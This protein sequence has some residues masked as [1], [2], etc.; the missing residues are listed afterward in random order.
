MRRRRARSR[1]R[2]RCL[3]PRIR[4]GG[5]WSPSRGSVACCA[6]LLLGALIALPLLAGGWLWLRQSLVRVRAARADRGRARSRGAGCGRGADAGG[7]SHE[8]A[9][10]E[11]RRAL[12]AAVAPLLVVRAVR[13]IP[14]LP[15]RP[16]HRG[17]RAAAR[18]EPHG[19][20]RAHSGGRRRRGARSGTAVRLAAER[21]WLGRAGSWPARTSGASLLA[22][23][24]VLGAAPAPLAEHVERVFT[25]AKGLTMAMR[26]GLLVYF[27][28]ATP[29]AREVAVAGAG[30]RRPELGRRLLR[31]R[32]PAL[33]PGRRVPGRR[34][35]AGRERA[36]RRPAPSEAARQ[37][38]IDRRLRSPRVCPPGRRDRRRPP[39]NRGQR[40]RPPAAGSCRR[41]DAAMPGA[42]RNATA[43]KQPRAAK[44][45][46]PRRQRCAGRPITLNLDLR[47]MHSVQA[48]SQ[49]VVESRAICNVCCES[50]RASLTGRSSLHNVH[51]PAVRRAVC[52]EP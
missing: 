24:A 48:D 35:P 22:D 39:P 26:N 8:H 28:D 15:A 1:S 20:G 5:R 52:C 40:L 10:R 7:A 12:R 2:A 3:A 50:G 14:E 19:G 49:A 33:P 17:Q 51:N 21:Q 42:E 34:D 45:E 11:R 4:G 6:S 30:A 32:A 43:G 41:H 25:G 46:D 37:R 29:P 44:R 18:R 47:F 9:R 23:L 13:A 38:G 31:R 16:A 36:Q 27:G